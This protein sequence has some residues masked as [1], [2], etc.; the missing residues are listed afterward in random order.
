MRNIQN[1][2]QNIQ[3]NI[4]EVTKQIIQYVNKMHIADKIY[5]EGGL[6]L[7][8]CEKKLDKKMWLKSCIQSIPYKNKNFLDK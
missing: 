3:P 2:L 5:Y 8:L 7:A 1:E 4:D 6:N